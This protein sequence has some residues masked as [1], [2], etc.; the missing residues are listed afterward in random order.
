VDYSAVLQS[1]SN[2]LDLAKG[3][4]GARPSSTCCTSAC[5]QIRLRQRCTEAAVAVRQK[6]LLALLL[7]GWK[8]APRRAQMMPQP[9]AQA[10]CQLQ[11]CRTGQTTLPGLWTPL[12]Y[13]CTAAED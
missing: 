10:L 13:K 6:V 5:L 12:V 7:L 11:C 9:A 3:S 2:T 4:Q 1:K 8:S